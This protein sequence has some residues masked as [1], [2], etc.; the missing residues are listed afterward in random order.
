MYLGDTKVVDKLVGEFI[1]TIVTD[2]YICTIP[3]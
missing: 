1:N 3:A 2:A